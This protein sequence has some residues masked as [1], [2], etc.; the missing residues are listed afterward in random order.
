VRG[1]GEAT[2]AITIVNALATG[3]GA[4]VG[5]DLRARAEVELHPAGSRGKWD[6]RLPEESRTPLV[7]ASLDAA[8]N[9]FAPGSA[10]TASLSLRS[11]IPTGRG[12]KSSSAVSSAL[13]LAVA[14]AT[15][16]R[17][18][19]LEVARLSAAAA[20]QSGVSATGAFDDALA[21]LATGVIVTNNSDRTILGRY[22]LPAGLEVALLIPRTTHSPS[23]E[24]RTSFARNAAAGRPAVEAALAGDWAG[25]MRWNTELVERLVGYD[26]A[27]V[28]AEL[29]EEGAVGCGVSGMGPALAAVAPRSRLP[30]V[31]AALPARLGDRRAVPFATSGDPIEAGTA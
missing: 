24:W 7:I 8:L 31:V 20:T 25:A 9:R 22:E 26:Y 13:V 29:S 30:N 11:D 17:P 1:V 15:D 21:G 27:T 28:R 16:A 12:L 10:G 23:P 3:V 5:I 6:V 2:A 19:A 4:A 18:D 14:E